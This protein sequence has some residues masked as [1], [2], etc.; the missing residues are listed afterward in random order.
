MQ[1][2]KYEETIG[3]EIE[4]SLEQLHQV[5]MVL[6]QNAGDPLTREQC[7]EIKKMLRD[8]R[9]TVQ[10]IDGQVDMELCK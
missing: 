3:T 10:S 7:V 9:D 4:M 1:Q 2:E 8:I 6:Q 5:K